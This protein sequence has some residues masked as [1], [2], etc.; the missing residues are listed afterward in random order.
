MGKSFMSDVQE[1]D[2][3][4]YCDPSASSNPLSFIRRTIVGVSC[5]ALCVRV[6]SFATISNA[7]LSLQKKEQSFEKYASDNA[8]V[9]RQQIRLWF[10]SWL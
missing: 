10:G 1:G 6:S 4:V 2:G 5:K 3:S 7:L 9:R 8:P